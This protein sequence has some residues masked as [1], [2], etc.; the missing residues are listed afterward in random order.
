EFAVTNVGSLGTQMAFPLVNPGQPGILAPGAVIDGRCWLTLCYDRGSFD[1][2]Q[3]E[4]LLERI[5]A[6]LTA[7]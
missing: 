7:G 4:A 6:E 5:A 1:P 3:A 2:D